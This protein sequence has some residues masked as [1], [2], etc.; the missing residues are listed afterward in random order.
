MIY[1]DEVVTE[2]TFK[3]SRSS[4]PG[5]QN[6]NKV[7]SKVTA[8]WHVEESQLLSDVEKNTIKQRLVHRINALGMLIV[9]SSE[10]RSQLENKELAVEKLMYLIN[11]ALRPVKKRIPT[12]I[13]KAKVLERLDRK[14][15]QATKKKDRK[16][17]LE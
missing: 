14:K 16:W 2:L 15:K 1:K 6:V 12:K 13:S 8:I 3:T 5:G 17:R 9:D 11:N 7:E 4:G 10:T